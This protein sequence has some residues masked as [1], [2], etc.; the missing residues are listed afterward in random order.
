MFLH[1]TQRVSCCSCCRRLNLRLLSI[2]SILSSPSSLAAAADTSS[3]SVK[4][5]PITP[6]KPSIVYKKLNQPLFPA[7]N[8]LTDEFGSSQALSSDISMESVENLLQLGDTLKQRRVSSIIE[9]AV[10]DVFQSPLGV[11]TLLGLH[12]TSSKGKGKGK[13]KSKS[14]LFKNTE[15]TPMIDL[16]SCTL[17]P[18]LQKAKII[19]SVFPTQPHT[20]ILKAN[21]SPSIDENG[22]RTNS[23]LA[24]WLSGEVRRRVRRGRFNVTLEFYDVGEREGKIFGSSSKGGMY[25]ELDFEQ[26]MREVEEEDEK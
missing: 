8:D 7:I 21:L 13:N 3:S 17:S 15:S 20:A 9:R 24:R 4:F 23:N 26:L 6:T 12:S 10:S 16:L 22:T 5:S 25:E 11:Q 19:Y 2:P 18:D 14:K 1:T